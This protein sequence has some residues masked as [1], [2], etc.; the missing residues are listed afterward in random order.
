MIVFRVENSIFEFIKMFDLKFL[1][2]LLFLF[3]NSDSGIS[4]LTGYLHY[5]LYAL[6]I[7]LNKNIDITRKTQLLDAWKIRTPR[8]I[9]NYIFIQYQL[10]CLG[11][12]HH[13]K[14]Y[15]PN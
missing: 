6:C 8:I 5:I 15:Q 1:D 10:S 3:F 13:A 14:K 9:L 2:Y 12:W 11:V 7:S 4:L